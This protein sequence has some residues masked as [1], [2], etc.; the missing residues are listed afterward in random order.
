MTGSLVLLGLPFAAL[1]AVV[2]GY[3][4]AERWL[5]ERAARRRARHNPAAGRRPVEA[6]AADIRRLGRQLDL[7]PAGAPMVRRRALQAAYDDVLV[8]AAGMLG[9]P[10][11]LAT[12]PP[13]R[14]RDVERLRLVTALQ[15]AGLAVGG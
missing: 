1:C 12:E 4:P 11:A 6:V 5:A 15:L 13:G 7:I 10:H 3:L 9:V 8:E 2:V 14:A